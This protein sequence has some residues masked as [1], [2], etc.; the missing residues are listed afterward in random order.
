MTEEQRTIL[1]VDDEEIV[2]SLL[3][4]TLEEAGYYVITA[5]NGLEA[6]DKVSQLDVS[7]VLLD[8]KMPGLDGFQVLDR[9]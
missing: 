5:V 3:Q 8:I 1:A 9:I 6:L 2:R 7:L 4:R